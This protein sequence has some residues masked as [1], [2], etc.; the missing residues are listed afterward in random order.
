LAKSLRL[1]SLYSV[2]VR[3][4]RNLMMKSSGVMKRSPCCSTD[5]YCKEKVNV[6]R[7]QGHKKNS[8]SDYMLWGTCFYVLFNIVPTLWSTL[9]NITWLY[10][11]CLRTLLIV[12][13]NDLTEACWHVTRCCQ[14]KLVYMT[15][16][17]PW[18]RLLSEHHF[19]PFWQT[20][21]PE[22]SKQR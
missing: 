19:Q 8:G 11:H 15:L 7:D 20:V 22:K 9:V 16:T 13:E 3:R 14:A 21:K 2:S 5:A 10:K 18:Q 4:P 12:E 6:Q 1:S 17:L